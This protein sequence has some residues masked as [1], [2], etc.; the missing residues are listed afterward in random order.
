MLSLS[1]DRNA[2]PRGG[3]G[4]FE[5]APTLVLC[6]VERGISI[7]RRRGGHLVVMGEGKNVTAP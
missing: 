7:A 5:R 4:I 6:P 2:A 3:T 1:T